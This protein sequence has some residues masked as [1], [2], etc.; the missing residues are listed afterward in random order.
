MQNISGNL[1]STLLVA[2]CHWSLCS[3][4]IRPSGVESVRTN[5][6]GPI[7]VVCNLT[8]T[9]NNIPRW[10]VDPNGICR[11]TVFHRKILNF[12]GIINNIG[13]IHL[14]SMTSSYIATRLEVPDSQGLI[15]MRVTCGD[16]SAESEE[17][18]LIK[19]NG[20]KCSHLCLETMLKY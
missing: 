11:Q 3:V 2:L 20:E 15:P 8:W 13:E 10:D 6:N 17:H 16:G 18:L 9:S 14:I 4:E 5:V 1:L 7:T 12:S 19:C